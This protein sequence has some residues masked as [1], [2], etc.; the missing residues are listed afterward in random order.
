MDDQRCCKPASAPGAFLGGFIQ[1]PKPIELLLAFR[2]EF[3]KLLPL[4]RD[5]VEIANARALVFD[6]LAKKARLD[7]EEGVKLIEDTLESLAELD[8]DIAKA[9]G[10]APATPEG[11]SPVEATEAAPQTSTEAKPQEGPGLEP[12]G[13]LVFSMGN[14]NIEPFL[15]QIEAILKTPGC[16]VVGTL[17]NKADGLY[18]V[19]ASA[20]GKDPEAIKRAALQ[21][22]NDGPCASV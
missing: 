9:E 19:F 7:A 11:D 4:A 16:S 8:R 3:Q 10:K 1:K 17:H 20:Q 22:F 6:N 14:P 13:L 5:K 18:R 21:R 12:V 2:D 15:C